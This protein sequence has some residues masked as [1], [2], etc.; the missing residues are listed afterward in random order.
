MK[1]VPVIVT[2]API[3]AEDGVKEETVGNAPV[4]VNPA[5]L[6]VPPFVVTL[7]LPLAP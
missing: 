1:F 6:L 4:Y 2:V 3:E 7:T 5:K